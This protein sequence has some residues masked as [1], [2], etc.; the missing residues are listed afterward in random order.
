MQELIPHVEQK[1]RGIGQPWARALTGCSTGGWEATGMQI[2]YP[3]FYNGT[4]A[5]A[6][7]PIDFRAWRLANIYDDVN[8]SWYEGAWGLVA[9]PG[10]GSRGQN[11]IAPANRMETPERPISGTL[12]MLSVMSMR[13]SRRRRISP[14][15]E[16]SNTG[17]DSFIVI[18]VIRRTRCPFRVERRS[19]AT[20]RNG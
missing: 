1:F 12:R 14:T 19:G 2:V 11:D 4:S 17:T 20:F 18:R 9:K 7:S 16:Q 13:S 10:I 5:G 15:A 6:A 8:T 3:D